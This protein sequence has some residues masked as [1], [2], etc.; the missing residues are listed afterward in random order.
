MIKFSYIDTSAF[1]KYYGKPEFEKGCEKVETI[2]NKTREGESILISSFLMVGEV[3]SVFDKWVRIKVIG[4]SNKISGRFLDEFK[5]PKVI[6]IDNV[7]MS[8][9]VL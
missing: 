5:K 8:T 9:G 6:Y 7:K 3:V 2:V 1:V 4:A